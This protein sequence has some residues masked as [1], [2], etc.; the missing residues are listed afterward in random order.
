MS[1]P[2][3]KVKIWNSS[4]SIYMAKTIQ[5]FTLKTFE[6]HPIQNAFW[7]V[8]DRFTLLECVW[9]C[10]AIYPDHFWCHIT[11]TWQRWRIPLYFFYMQWHYVTVAYV[12]SRQPDKKLCWIALN[13]ND[14]DCIG[15]ALKLGVNGHDGYSQTDLCWIEFRGAI[16]RNRFRTDLGE[17][18]P[19]VTSS[20]TG[21]FQQ[22]VRFQVGT[23]FLVTTDMLVQSALD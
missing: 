18:M 21:A 17:I 8:W 23:N 11:S 22:W 5:P 15:I 6:D 19:I 3:K 7:S 20:F 2:A 9:M 10:K 4:K 12:I 1:A 14:V 13:V 16:W